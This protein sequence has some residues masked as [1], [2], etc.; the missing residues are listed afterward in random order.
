MDEKHS[1]HVKLYAADVTPL[2]D[3]A[4]YV[5]ARAAVTAQRREKA[6]RYR[7]DS[8]KRL[9]L[10]AGVLLSYGLKKAGIAE[11][12][13]AFLYG[14]NGKPYIDGQDVFFSLSHS[15]N[16]ALCAVSDCEVGCDIER[17]KPVD[18]KLAR[19]FSPGEYASILR[20]DEEKRQSLFYR[21][22]TLKESFMKATGLGFSLPLEQFQIELNDGISV[23][24][25][26]DER[27]HVFREFE[28]IEGYQCALC[29]AASD[30]EAELEIVDLTELLK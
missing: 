13:E 25:S 12:P 8:D 27:S 1:A 21:F 15:G 10:G 16:W 23:I 4:L 18:I 7:F 17:I 28:G 22:W 24:H 9:A 14:E 5:S 30:V 19:R 2:T 29:A 6:D 20:A 11:L 26:V 3:A